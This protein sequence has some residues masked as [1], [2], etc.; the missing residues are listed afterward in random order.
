M[1]DTTPPPS[2][3]PAA[4]TAAGPAFVTALRDAAPY[5]HAHN[6]QTFVIAFGGETCARA[7]FER[8][9]YDIALVSS[10]GVKLVLVH[11][12]R[13]QID[14]R[15][16]SVGLSRKTIGD[17]RVTYPAMM[18]HVKSAVGALRM[19]IEARLSTGLASTPMGGARLRIAGGNWITA[20][21]VGVRDG[22]DHHLTGEVRRVD[23]ESI[24]EAL[25]QERIALLSPVGYSPTG[26]IFNLRSGDVAEAVAAGLRADKLIFVLNSDPE[27]WQLAAETGDAGQMT[28][29][30][31]ERLLSRAAEPAGDA[32]PLSDEDRI[33]IRA[34]LRA[35]H[36][37][38]KRV[39]LIG[40][41][42]DGGLLRELYT[43]DGCGLMFY[44]DEDYEATRDATIEDVGG[45]LALIK[46]LEEAGV[47]APRSREQLE[48][49]IEHFSVMVRDGM[50]IAC[51]ALLPFP[52]SEAGE[53]A[54]VAVHPDYRQEGRAGAL[55]KRVEAQARKRG[56]KR[57]FALTT[58]TPHWFIEHGFVAAKLED[59]PM[60]RQSL[61]NFQR[62]SLVLVKDL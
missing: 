57:L 36:E 9:I 19:D 33:Y 55:L 34:A 35:G 43:R 50:V 29:S 30:E 37:G 41:D 54:C 1:N 44:A 3:A 5:V 18:E 59:L 45:V 62:N 51:S 28:L 14:A 22:V 61:Y 27:A 32:K 38:V 31:A 13:H 26:E 17:L 23:I 53:L 42:T 52:E 11:G 4:G 48:L 16:K 56:L 8:L 58:H 40:A 20:R 39:H 10:L 21:P 25:L 6:G 12:S 7:D 15:L 24:R 2:G 46:P 60:R 49:E 47:L